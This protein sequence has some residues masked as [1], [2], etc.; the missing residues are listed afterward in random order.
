V[1]GASVN[2]AE[3]NPPIDMSA[4]GNF[5]YIG[6]QQVAN[7]VVQ[8]L[9]GDVA[10]V[11]AVGGFLSAPDLARLETYLKSKYALTP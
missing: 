6:G 2:T 5:V 4:V 10:E 1:N 3:F 9:D 8:Q 11:V 7:G